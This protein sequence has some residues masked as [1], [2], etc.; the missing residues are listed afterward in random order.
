MFVLK[1]QVSYMSEKRLPPAAYTK[2]NYEPQSIL[3]PGVLT[4]QKHA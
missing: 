1:E 2:R 3:V 4:T